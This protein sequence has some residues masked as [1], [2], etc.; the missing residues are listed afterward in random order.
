MKRMQNMCTINGWGDLSP[1]FKIPQ[2]HGRSI[3]ALDG[4]ST[5]TGGSFGFNTFRRIRLKSFEIW[6]ELIINLRNQVKHLGSNPLK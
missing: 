3:V 5:G 2:A 4:R 1:R 6:V